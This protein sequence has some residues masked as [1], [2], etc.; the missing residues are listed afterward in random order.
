MPF[1]WESGPSLLKTHALLTKYIKNNP[2]ACKI[3]WIHGFEK[4]RFHQVL[5]LRRPHAYQIRSS[6]LWD[7]LRP[8]TSAHLAK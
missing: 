3:S 7:V 1:L 2:K 8:G 5:G 4:S 6:I